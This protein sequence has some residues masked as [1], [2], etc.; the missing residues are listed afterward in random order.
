MVFIT[1]NNRCVKIIIGIALLLLIF[2]FI[3]NQRTIKSPSLDSF[4]NDSKPSD[5]ENSPVF[6]PLYSD[7]KTKL[8]VMLISKP[9]PSDNDY[10]LYV[11]NK[12]KYI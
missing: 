7:D 10:K 9:F 5:F 2:Y 3:Y 6:V 1:D 4:A 11:N 12:H 8:N